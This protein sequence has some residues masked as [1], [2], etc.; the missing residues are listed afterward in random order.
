MPDQS[1]NVDR[2]QQSFPEAASALLARFRQGDLDAFEAIF[3]DHQRTVYGWILRMV[4]DPGAAED[5]MVE[6]FWR[7]YRARSRFDPA[8][9]FAPWARRVAT[10]A[11]LDWMRT[12]RPETVLT[13]E[14]ADAVPAGAVGICAGMRAEM[15]EKIARAFARLPARLR[16]AALLAVV[17]ER[18]HKEVAAAL[19]V[20]TGAVKL[21]VFRALRL[22]RKDLER[23]GIKP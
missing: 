6:T 3:R 16:I 15:R 2:V 8:R 14:I 7:I 11:A 17:E 18:P 5:L 4:R 1:C 23:E 19:G 20:S 9:E 12:R 10:R 21:R 22:L 13:T